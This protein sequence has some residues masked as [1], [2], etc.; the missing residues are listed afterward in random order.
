MPLSLIEASHIRCTVRAYLS[1]W[2]IWC[3]EN[4]L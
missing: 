2:I 4:T 3:L 1:Q